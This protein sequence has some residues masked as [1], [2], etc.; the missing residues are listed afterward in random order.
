M[1]FYY[2][3]DEIKKY[4]VMKA[5]KEL[6]KLVKKLDLL[7][8][9]ISDELR[10]I[11]DTR[12]MDFDEKTER[13]QDGEHGETHQEKTEEIRDIKDEVETHLV[14]IFDELSKFDNL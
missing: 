6:I 11:V 13:W 1:F 7:K 14:D 5:S 2:L 10:E 12:E 9:Q 8:D 4:Y 3:Y